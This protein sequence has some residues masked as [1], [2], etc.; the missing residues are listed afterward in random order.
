MVLHP[1][2]EV[3]VGMLVTV[4]ISGCQLMVDVLGYRKRRQ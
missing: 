4:R 2:T 1:L 3:G